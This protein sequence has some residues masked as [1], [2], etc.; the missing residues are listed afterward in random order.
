MFGKHN[1]THGLDDSKQLRL[2]L[3]AHYIKL[4]V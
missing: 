3:V 4:L 2:H 1:W